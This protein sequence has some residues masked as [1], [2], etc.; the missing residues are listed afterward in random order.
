[1]KGAAHREAGKQWI[2]F[3]H[4]PENQFTMAVKTK[5]PVVN[6]KSIQMLKE[7]GYGWLVDA[8]RME[9]TEIVQQ[10]LVIGPPKDMDAWVKAW[11]E[12]KAA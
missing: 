1:M 3:F 9:Q 7:K 10:M 2:N 11:N 5:Y 8:V 4:A 12:V 6:K